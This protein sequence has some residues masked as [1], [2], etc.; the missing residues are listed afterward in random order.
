MFDS[1]PAHVLQALNAALMRSGSDRFST[2]VFA[3][4]DGP[5]AGGGVSLRIAAGGHPPA[6][7]CRAD[8]TVEECWARGPLLGIMSS[9]ELEVLDRRLE[10]GDR[11]VLYTDG[12][13]ESRRGGEIFGFERLA[14]A[15]AELRHR[16]AGEIA[17]AL[18]ERSREYGGGQL[19]DDVAV[20]VLGVPAR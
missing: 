15:L 16:P 17:E 14:A 10:P 18:V 13:V 11:L 12:L 8:G 2:A 4:L 7:I 6:M 5:V 3:R 1:D 20:V 19:S 9:I